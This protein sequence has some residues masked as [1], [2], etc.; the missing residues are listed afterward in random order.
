[1]RHEC[2]QRDIE[3][4]INII[5]LIAAHVLVCE[6]EMTDARCYGARY[7]AVLNARAR[8]VAAIFA[9]MPACFAAADDAAGYV[10]DAAL[11][12]F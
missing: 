6:L 11:F 3:F 4:I 12:L 7:E 10:V 9:M 8:V 1:M 5:Y 2:A